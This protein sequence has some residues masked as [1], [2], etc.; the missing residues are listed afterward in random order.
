MKKKKREDIKESGAGE[1]FEESLGEAVSACAGG[2]SYADEPAADEPFGGVL[3][4]FFALLSRFGGTRALALSLAKGLVFAAVSFVFGRTSLMLD[5][6]PL[7]IAFLASA[8]KRV[9]FIL[10][11]AV[12][13]AF[14]VSAEEGVIFSPYVYLA[15]YVMIFLIR[16]LSCVFF[17]PSVRMSLREKVGGERGGTLRRFFSSLWGE[18]VYLRMASATV[19]AFLVSLYAM[20]VGEYRLYDLF[21]AIFAMIS[22]PAIAYIFGGYFSETDTRFG[23][24]LREVSFIAISFCVMFGLGETYIFSVNI[25][26]ALGF[27]GVLWFARKRGIL[28]SAIFGIVAGLAFS[29]LYAPSFVLAAIAC[30][31]ISS[32]SFAALSVSV[33]VALLWGMYIDGFSA[34]TGFFPALVCSAVASVPLARIGS[35][36]EPVREVQMTGIALSEGTEEKML[37][38][39]RAFSDLSGALYDI[40]ERAKTPSAESIHAICSDAFE[41]CCSS[42]AEFGACRGSLGGDYFD[43][44]GRT[45][46]ALVRDGRLSVERLPDYMTRIC[47]SIGDIADNINTEYSVL[48]K[49]KLTMQRTE[50]FALDYEAVSRVIEEA[51]ELSKREN[52]ID[53]ALCDAVRSRARIKEL[54]MGPIYIYGERKKKLFC[55]D[56]GKKAEK[57]GALDLKKVLESACGFPLTSPVFELKG[58]KVA[59]S[60]ESD[61]RFDI[62]LGSFVCESEGETVCGDTLDA[63]T[64]DGRFYL[65][66]SDGMGSGESAAR[67]SAISALFL[68]KMLGAGNRK[69][70]ALKMLNNLLLSNGEECS[71]SID[72]LELDLILGKASFI[73][74][75]AA[76]SFVRRGDNLYKLRSGTAPI[77]IMSAIDSEQMRFGIEDGDVIIMLSDGVS[78]TPEDCFWLMQMLSDA[79][80]WQG[81]SLDALSKKIGERA[82][83]EGSTDDISVALI[84]IKEV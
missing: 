63:F 56:I 15:T 66:I 70:T 6:Y 13:S 8:E 14:S 55:P 23:R 1:I 17:D 77:G 10:M 75:G 12:L 32:S 44:L 54:G 35:R 22:A 9:V 39:S 80:S 49:E 21:S 51:I 27:S 30:G 3:G 53:R 45:E 2:D 61:K 37:E 33:S 7:A 60:S 79:E 73:K 26:A 57:M 11:G 52:K 24:A 48:I 42:C 83:E 4:G 16:L 64:S 67:V 46:E 82:R 28:Y 43:M 29:P 5:T 72:L 19:G 31:V 36:A 62:E 81:E 78:Q 58:D 76:P 65:L 71:A 68:T 34:L 38:L 59:L 18:T 69:E 74:S 41:R 40:S 20:R 47:P 50:L 84:R 25:G